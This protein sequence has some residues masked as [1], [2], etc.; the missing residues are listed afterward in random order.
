MKARIISYMGDG[1]ALQQKRLAWHNRQLDW[2][3]ARGLEVVVFDQDYKESWYRSDPAI[4]YARYKGPLLRP[5]PARNELLRDFYAS[6]E[7]WTVMA[8]NDSV[9]VDEMD[10]HAIFSLLPEVADNI[11]IFSPINGAI[12]G[13]PWK[14]KPDF[15]ADFLVFER[16]VDLKGSFWFLRKPP[17]PIWFHDMEIGE[18]GDF[19]Y[20]FVQQGLGTF[21]CHNI[22]LR[23]FA[24]YEG[25]STL[26]DMETRKT[27]HAK[28]K[29]FFAGTFPGMRYENG[30]LNK[31][32]FIARFWQGP[33]GHT[34]EKGYRK[35]PTGM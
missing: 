26:Y 6:G 7:T 14:A 2:L 25:S 34:I 17:D 33:R 3:L 24:A 30:R 31:H 35:P 19:V 15:F 4:T 10:G 8:D 11:Y 28:A 9:L 29:A 12:R 27:V 5:G 1:S 13:Y 32:A 22:A 16:L 23:E 18:D 21:Q 20:Q